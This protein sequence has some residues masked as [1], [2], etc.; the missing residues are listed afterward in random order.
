MSFWNLFGGGV[1]DS[2]EKI[3]TEWIETDKEKAEAGMIDAKAKSLFVKVLDP[4]GKMRKQIS[5]DV[6]HLY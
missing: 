6:F 1:V 3:A 5:N 4:N 2:V